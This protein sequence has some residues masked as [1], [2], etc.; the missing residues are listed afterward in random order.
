M[1]ERCSDS[2][3]QIMRV[4]CIFSYQWCMN[5]IYIYIFIYIYRWTPRWMDFRA[6]YSIRLD[7][8][9]YTQHIWSVCVR[10]VNSVCKMALFLEFRK[11]TRAERA[12]PSIYSRFLKIIWLSTT[13]YFP[14][15]LTLVD[16][17]LFFRLHD[18][19]QLNV[20]WTREIECSF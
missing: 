13:F 7:W 12:N 8:N 16:P 15:P 6:M 10:N 3:R 4:R 14:H 11:C 9:S 1:M 20:R 19:S 2:T 5:N 17:L 18:P